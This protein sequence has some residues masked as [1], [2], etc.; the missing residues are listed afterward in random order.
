MSFS[1][2]FADG[3]SY[4]IHHD[5]LNLIRTTG[6]E[7]LLTSRSQYIPRY[8]AT[9][10]A[11]MYYVYGYKLT[12][13]YIRRVSNKIP[14]ADFLEMMLADNK[15]YTIPG[16]DNAI[17]SLLYTLAPD[18]LEKDSLIS[19]FNRKSKEDQQEH[20]EIVDKIN[21]VREELDQLDGEI[22]PAVYEWMSMNKLHS[23]L[24]DLTNMLDYYKFRQHMQNRLPY[25]IIGLVELASSQ[26]G[27]E[28]SPNYK[29]NIKTRIRGD[30]GLMKELYVKTRKMGISQ[31][32]QLFLSVLTNFAME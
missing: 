24:I 9:F 17:I 28:L 12:R 22:G 15:Y 13:S 2:K 18:R 30:E 25:V 19:A 14:S 1:V 31:T 8:G 23:T 27:R 16:I 10:P 21:E 11:F 5:D 26:L 20:I 6:L 32:A 3:L 7:K 29:K 4:E